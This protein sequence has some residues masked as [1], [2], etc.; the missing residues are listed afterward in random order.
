MLHQ[1]FIGLIILLQFTL[2]L[3]DH[4]FTNGFAKDLPPDD[5]RFHAYVLVIT[6]LLIPTAGLAYFTEPNQ[7]VAIV[8]VW[9]VYLTWFGGLLDWIYF[10]AKTALPLPNKKWTWMPK[11]FPRLEN[12]V[13]LFDYPTNRE[14]AIYTICMWLPNIVAWVLIFQ[15]L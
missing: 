2:A 10:I 6:M 1:T 12:G 14:W 4:L 11:I 8:K 7:T 3:L 5:G 13:L 15:C 9:T